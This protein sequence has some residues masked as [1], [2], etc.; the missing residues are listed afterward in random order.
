MAHGQKLTL[1]ALKPRQYEFEVESPDGEMMVFTFRAPSQATF[2]SIDADNKAPD[3]AK[4][5][6]TFN[7]DMAGNIIPIPDDDAY[8]REFSD[9]IQRIMFKKIL[10]IWVDSETVLKGKTEEDRLVE[11]SDLAAWVISALWKIT[12]ML[13]ATGT[14]AINARTFRGD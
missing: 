4:F 6:K 9:Y 2:W 5:A 7:K 11:M 3:K 12:Q 10:E 14:D 1:D 8:Q 13:M